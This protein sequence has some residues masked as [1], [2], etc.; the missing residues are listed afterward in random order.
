MHT[1]LLGGSEEGD[2][3][4]LQ[5]REVWER[6]ALV[7]RFLELRSWLLVGWDTHADRFTYYYLH[8]PNSSEYSI[9]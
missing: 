5:G 1:K 7:G 3:L 2:F 4:L 6:Y 8:P 9:S